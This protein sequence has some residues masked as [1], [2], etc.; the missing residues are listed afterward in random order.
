MP[1]LIGTILELVAKGAVTGAGSWGAGKA[2]S[3]LFGGG[4]GGADAAALDQIEQELGEITTLINELK[5]SIQQLQSDLQKD[6]EAVLADVAATSLT[7]AS[8]S[9]QTHYG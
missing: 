4:E 9:I 7:T 1:V 6:I 2:L 5:A 8:T 3:A